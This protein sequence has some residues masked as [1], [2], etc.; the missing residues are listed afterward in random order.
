MR[1][2]PSIIVALSIAAS[3]SATDPQLFIYRNDSRFNQLSLSDCTAIS[4]DLEASD[5]SRHSLQADEITVPLD[6]IDSCVV[7]HTYIPTLHF[8]FTD[9]PE[10]TGLWDK[11]LYLNATLDVTG[12]GYVDDQP[13]LTL[14]VKGRG[15]STWSMPKKPIRLKFDKKTALCGFKKAK[16][17]AL[18]ANYLDH[19][20]LRNALSMWLA[21]RIGVPYANHTMPCNVIINDT[22]QGLFLLTEK[23]GINAG[24]VD[25]DEETG[26]LVELSTEFDEP[27]QFRSSL[28]QMPVMVKDPDFDELYEDDPD[29]L[30]PSQR[31]SLWYDDFNNAERKV[32]SGKGFDAFDLEAFVKY[33]MLYNITANLELQHPKSLYIHKLALGD[34]NK[35]IFG[36]AWDFDVAY[37]MVNPAGPQYA[38]N[39]P[40]L[41]FKGMALINKLTS[42]PGFLEAYRIEFENFVENIY[43]DMLQFIDSYAALIQ[44]A[45]KLD[46]LRWTASEPIGSWAYRIPSFKAE[47][48]IPVFR[49]WI[50]DRITFLSSRVADGKF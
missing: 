17:Y 35:Y 12:Y 5:I 29:G 25:I 33:I 36:P 15:N 49:Q 48:Y 37:N 4:H 26:I 18:L 21:Q 16:S 43:P 45:A 46:G 3:A 44:P 10:A 7:R 24:S 50:Q 6:A 19:T 39:S 42:T 34:D 14:S 47:T 40:T 27:H 2:L 38:Q 28:Y 1:L 22:P 9:Y 11:E 32:A 8:R 23:I 41:P 30:T 13:G 31:L 20:H